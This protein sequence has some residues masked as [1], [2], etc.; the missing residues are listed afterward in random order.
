MQKLNK[1]IDDICLLS[2]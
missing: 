1:T 2:W